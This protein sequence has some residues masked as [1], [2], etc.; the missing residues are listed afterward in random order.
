M[1]RPTLTDSTLL[2]PCLP[3][4]PTSSATSSRTSE[5][6]TELETSGVGCS[7]LFLPVDWRKANLPALL[8]LQSPTRV[9]CTTSLPS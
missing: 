5:L 4:R 7:V 3:R 8:L 1:W 9:S 6:I 2:P